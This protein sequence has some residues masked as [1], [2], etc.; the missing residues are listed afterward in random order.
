[1]TGCGDCLEEGGERER[2]ESQMVP[3]FQCGPLTEPVVDKDYRMR[4][5]FAGQDD[6]FFSGYVGFEVPG[7]T[8]SLSS[9]FQRMSCNVSVK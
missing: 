3:G 1:M 4:N 8:T 7:K 9:V 6:E 5:W 2:G